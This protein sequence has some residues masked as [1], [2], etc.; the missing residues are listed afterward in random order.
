MANFADVQSMAMHLGFRPENVDL[1]EQLFRISNEGDGIQNLLVDCEDLIVVLEQ[2]I[3]PVTDKT[4]Y[5]QLMQMNRELV[6]GA[7]CADVDGK[8][9][10]WRDTLRLDTLDLEELAGSINALSLAM[11]EHAEVLLSMSC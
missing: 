3:M 5:R 4:D 10:L 2:A 8:W 6:H 7:F 1:S 9:I 11:A